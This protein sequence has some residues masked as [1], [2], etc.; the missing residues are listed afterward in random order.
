[1]IVHIYY[2]PQNA[3]L[4]VNGEQVASINLS[5]SD[6][7]FP[8]PSINGLSNDWFGFY[9]YENVSPIQ[10]DCVSIYPYKMSIDLAKINFVKGQA[11]ESPEKKRT[12][13]SSAPFEVDFQYSKNANSYSYPGLGSWQH[14]VSDNMAVT[15]TSIS[16]PSY[17]IPGFTTQNKTK[18]IDDWYDFSKTFL[19]PTTSL[20]SGKII[21]N[22]QY[23]RLSDL[24]MENQDWDSESYLSFASANMT[25]DNTVAF[26]STIQLPATLSNQ[27]ITKIYDQS[28][29]SFEILLVGDSSS[30]TPTWTV[31]YV[32]KINGRAIG[33]PIKSISVSPS[34]DLAIGI[35]PQKIV[36]NNSSIV[37]L[38]SF[39]SDLRSLKMSFGGNG[40][41]S[42]TFT[43]KVYRIGFCNQNNYDKVFDTY[44]SNS[45]GVISLGNS[46]S[47]AN[48]NLL[49]ATYTLF[50]NYTF[51]NLILDIATYGEFSDHIPLS[52]LATNVLDTDGN[53]VSTIDS[54]QVFSSIPDYDVSNSITK[55]YARLIDISQPIVDATVTRSET[56]NGL[57]APDADDIVTSRYSIKTDTAIILPQTVLQNI[58]SYAIEISFEFEIPGII[59]NPLSVGK[60]H[61]SSYGI[62]KSADSKTAIGSR[63]GTDVFQYK[64]TNGLTRYNSFVPYSIYKDTTPYVHLT[65]Y[66]GIR[67]V[68]DI[69]TSEGIL[70]PI[71]P[72][73]ANS[74]IVSVM[75]MSILH[76]DTFPVD[77]VEIARIEGFKDD[78]TS[79]FNVILYAKRSDANGYVADVYAEIYDPTGSTPG[80]E[81]FTSIS[82]HVNGIEHD[83]YAESAIRYK[84]WA[85]LSVSFTD[86]MFFNTKTTGAIKITGPFLFN[87]FTDYQLMPY[88]VGKSRTFN[89]WDTISTTKL[90]STPGTATWQDGIWVA[91]TQPVEG[92]SLENIYNSYFGSSTILSDSGDTTFTVGSVQK[93][94]YT[95]NDTSLLIK[96]PA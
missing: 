35:N 32:F 44:F 78:Y 68:G 83:H 1:M 93:N 23:F 67:K 29:R 52:V 45:D 59:R 75:Q 39:F 7:V 40:S 53:S 16:A 57:L 20:S 77:P 10:V 69:S 36:L 34:Q 21:D 12:S 65:N 95:G 51:S 9:A 85:V 17:S 92:L 14:G 54:I 74:Y 60:L 88:Q 15:Y 22:A 4:Y 89:N 31:D 56:I 76:R 90:W 11:V 82:I 18:T 70:L 62:N 13:Y 5:E 71:N 50:S 33:N 86:F 64:T 37:D 41:F 8:A 55:M 87:N 46:I 66:S 63:Y 19:S 24:D 6:K 96:K 27:T 84:E 28:G 80:Y 49:I 61:V 81:S 91:G 72:H 48:F 2:T 30:S 38:K 3:G 42:D 43:G 79:P 26:Y 25:L 73:G 94:I 58:A 47:F